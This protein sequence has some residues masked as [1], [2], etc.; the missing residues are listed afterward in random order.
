ML[1][2]K[3]YLLS[4]ADVCRKFDNLYYVSMEAMDIEGKENLDKQL[5]PVV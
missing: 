1:V 2:R 3:L 5:R 4:T